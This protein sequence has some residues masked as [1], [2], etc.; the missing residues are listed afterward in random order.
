MATVGI[1]TYPTLHSRFLLTQISNM[2]IV[3]CSWKSL[4]L[5]GFPRFPQSNVRLSP[6]SGENTISKR[7]VLSKEL[8]SL[9]F[10]EKR[11]VFDHISI[12]QAYIWSSPVRKSHGSIH[13]LLWTHPLRSS[14]KIANI[15]SATLH[16]FTRKPFWCLNLSGVFSSVLHDLGSLQSQFRSSDQL[17]IPVS[18]ANNKHLPNAWFYFTSLCAHWC[19][20]TT[21]HKACCYNWS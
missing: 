17:N 16:P 21:H 6:F 13:F 4:D 9:D 18:D 8:K 1:F 10:H 2:E 7:I 11:F 15:D 14:K 19:I 3:N 12:Q 20:R 5:W